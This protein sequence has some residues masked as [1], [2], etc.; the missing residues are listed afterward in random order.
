M[1]N[2]LNLIV[3]SLWSGTAAFSIMVAFDCYFGGANSDLPV[4][5]QIL[6]YLKRS[7]LVL[8]LFISAFSAQQVLTLLTR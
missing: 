5:E 2:F 6:W 7:L 1:S 3:I 8:V 4:D